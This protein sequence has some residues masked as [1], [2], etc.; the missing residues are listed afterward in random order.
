MP[1]IIPSKMSLLDQVKHCLRLKH[2]IIRTEAAYVQAIRRFILYHRKRHP[3]EMGADEIRRFLSHL[4]THG[5]VS[6]SM[7]NVALAAL[8]FPYREVLGR[9]ELT[10][11]DGVE[12]AK[13]PTRVP[14]VLTRQEVASLLAQLSGMVSA[15]SI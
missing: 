2:Y 5:Q 15:F 9:E 10:Y 3:K 13:L 8:L 1:N 7:Q 14:T 4:A 6:A 12:R 11:M